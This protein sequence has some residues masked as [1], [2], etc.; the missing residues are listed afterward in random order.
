MDADVEDSPSGSEETGSESERGSFGHQ[1]VMYAPNTVGFPPARS[2]I[3][4]CH[5]M[6]SGGN[7]LKKIFEFVCMGFC[8]CSLKRC[9]GVCLV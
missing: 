5:G 7:V 8:I 1:G 4:H 6:A 3:G 9:V 2:A